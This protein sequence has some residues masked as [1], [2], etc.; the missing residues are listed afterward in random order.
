MSK[1][2]TK[3][4]TYKAMHDSLNK[5]M[6]SE[7]Y[8]EAIFI[9]Y[10]IIEDRLRSVL[11]HA[12]ISFVNK[13]GKEDK[14]SRKIAKIYSR[15][16]FASKQMRN[17]IPLELLDSLNEWIERRNAL[18]HNLANIRIED[19]YQIAEIAISGKE[20]VNSLSNSV[21]KANNW[22]LKIK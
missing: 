15:P 21:K 1:N 22:C 16:E 3:Y 4:E 14:I 11:T 10:A 19:M 20:L 5:A 2:I 7:F 8:F 9:E 6:K 17:K 18:I 12:N 13:N